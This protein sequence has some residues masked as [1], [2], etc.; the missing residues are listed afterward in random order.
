LFL[1]AFAL[2]LLV[3]CITI[4]LVFFFFFFFFF[5]SLISSIQQCTGSF[6]AWKQAATAA[7]GAALVESLEL[8]SH[9]GCS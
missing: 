4:V 5:V 3:Q 2:W 1:L 7:A 6:F 8:Q 9:V